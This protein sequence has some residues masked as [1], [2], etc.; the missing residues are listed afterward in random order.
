[1][2]VDKSLRDVLAAFASPR[3]TPGG[4]SAS[5]LAAA[6]GAALLRMVAALP[7]TR[8]GSEDD[9]SALTA[10]AAGLTG[11][12]QQLM[13]AVDGDAAAYDAV[14]AAYRQ[15]AS[16]DAE[17]AGRTGAIARAMHRATDVPLGVMRLSVLGLTHAETVAA[18]GHRPAASDVGVAIALLR[19]G[20]HGARLNVAIN[21]GGLS[22]AAYREAVAVEVQRLA[23]GADESAAAA[24]LSLEPA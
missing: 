15:P 22:D 8:T 5:A 21:L 3:P 18:H 16:T 13:E 17:R 2:L 7:K 1:M 10:A 24:E 19:A 12:Q 20:L 14:V 23:R 6:T 4:G 9:R 11:V